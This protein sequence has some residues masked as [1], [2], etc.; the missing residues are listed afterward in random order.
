MDKRRPLPRLIACFSAGALYGWSALTAPLQ[1]AFDV[2]VAQAGLVFSLALM[3]FTGAVLLSPLLT[4]R[5][6]QVRSLALAALLAGGLTAGAAFAP[7][8]ALFAGLFG[9][10]FGATSGLIYATALSLAA[11]G[12]SARWATPLSVATFGLGGVVFGPLWKSLV[13]ADWGLLALLPLSL[14][15][16]LASGLVMLSQT[17]AQASAQTTDR[18]KVQT[19]AQ[20]SAP[21]EARQSEQAVRVMGPGL[22]VLIWLIFAASAFAGLMVLGLA[23]KIMDVSQSS[24]GLTSAILA[25]IAA[26]NTLG[27]LSAALFGDRRR[28]VVRGLLLSCALTFAGLATAALSSGGPSGSL[29]LGLGLVL[30]AGGYGLTASS[31]PLLTAHHSEAGSFQR[32]F[33]LIFT[34]WG[35]A[36]FVAPWLTGRLFDLRGDFLLAFAVAAVTTLLSAGLILLF[37][38]RLSSDN[39]SNSGGS[40]S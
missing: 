38:R 10:G 7:T 13:A 3:S 9:L 36:G 27:R 28:R 12:P 16:V 14:L 31:I 5:I 34:A 19:T 32:Q 37:R 30:I 1:S 18:T 39:S 6:G 24:L 35:V 21:P 25:G 23:A 33:G 20:T 40:S 2:S 29:M 4:G 11:G 17:S 22:M 26:A 8:F 15:L